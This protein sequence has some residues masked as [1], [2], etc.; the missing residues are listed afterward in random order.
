MADVID[1]IAQQTDGMFVS[2]DSIPIPCCHPTCRSA[3]YAY[4]E[5]GEVTPLPRVVEVEKYLDY[6]TNRTLPDIRAD[7][8]EAL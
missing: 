8:L 3:T 1:G 2:S 4:V 6:I 7:V 5:N